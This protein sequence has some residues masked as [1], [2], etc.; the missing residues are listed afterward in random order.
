MLYVSANLPALRSSQLQGAFDGFGSA[1]GKEHSGH[2]R[3]FAETLGQP[4]RPGIGVLRR[5]VHHQTR[6]LGHSSNHA[7]MHVTQRVDA[8]PCHHVQV[9]IS[10]G[11]EQRAAVAA[12]HHHGKAGV[13]RDQMLLVAFE[14]IVCR[15]V[16]FIWVEV[17]PG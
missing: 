7:R 16:L 15:L 14:R 6:L 8:Q 13:Y 5:K 3:Q 10:V 17:L 12:F 11:I 2:A 1:C 9:A 4:T